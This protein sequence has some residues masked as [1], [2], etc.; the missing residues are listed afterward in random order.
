MEKRLG[1][2]LDLKYWKIIH[3]SLPLGCGFWGGFSCFYFPVFFTGWWGGFVC[4]EF[5]CFAFKIWPHHITCRIPDY[6]VYAGTQAGG[7]KA[8]TPNP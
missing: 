7:V 6:P 5:F 3:S 1:R 2:G 4:L 8:Q